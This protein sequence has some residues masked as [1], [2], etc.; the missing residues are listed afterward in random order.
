MNLGVA[1]IVVGLLTALLLSAYV[2]VA[3]MLVGAFVLVA[4][5]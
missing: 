1:L 2:G 5:R 4:G 3:A